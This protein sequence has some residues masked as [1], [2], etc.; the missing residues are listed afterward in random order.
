MEYFPL[1]NLPNDILNIIILYS[2]DFQKL[3]TAQTVNKL[4]ESVAPLQ[5]FRAVNKR[6]KKLV[7]LKTPTDSLINIK[8]ENLKAYIPKHLSNDKSIKENYLLNKRKIVFT[9]IKK[10]LIEKCKINPNDLT[11]MDQCNDNQKSIDIGNKIFLSFSSAI[12]K[13][14]IFE[15]LL[16][17]NYI[18]PDIKDNDG[19]VPLH[20]ATKFGY[21]NIVELLC[22]YGA[23]INTQN[24]E[25]STPLHWASYC[26]AIKTVILLCNK[27]AK[28]NIQDND[29]WTPLHYA[30]HSGAIENVKLLYDKGAIINIKNNKGRT[31]LDIA[32][33]ADHI[34]TAQLLRNCAAIQ[35]YDKK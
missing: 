11:F 4:K 16:K 5:N 1:I 12:S 20:Y 21:P 30:S 32:E 2:V 17:N 28:V 8:L 25:K 23:D 33:S 6:M 9:N 10:I 29:G 22:E 15:L 7:D 3:K 19:W 18:N 34:E 13:K 31:A 24:Q 27:G 26:N 35:N 14:E